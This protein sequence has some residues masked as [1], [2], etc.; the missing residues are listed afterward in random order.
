MIN[1]LKR[2]GLSMNKE[3]GFTL[4]EVL[5]AMV[6]AMVIMAGSYVFF[7]TQ[8]K[9]SVIQTNVSDAQQTLRAAM[10]FMAREFRMIGYDPTVSGNFS[11]TD[12]SDDSGMSAISYSWDAVNGDGIIDGND[13]FRFSLANA[14]PVDGVLDLTRDVGGS[15]SQLMA[16]NIMALGIAY[17]IDTNGDG[18][19][20]QDAGGNT[21]WFIDANNDLDWDQLTVNQAAGTNALADT[22][23]PVKFGDIRSIRIWMLAQSGAPDPNYIDTNI[24]VVGPH[25]SSPASR[26]NNNFR[27]RMQERT[28][29]CRN[30]GMN[31]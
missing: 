6:V 4:I 18:T 31:L 29:L 16:Q 25:I 20:E 27:H 13:T 9:Q 8:Q 11:I 10:D 1:E 19:L 17:A 15:G 28:V 26:P 23:V 22:G 2:M 12:I 21:A 5:I 14:A 24:Y 30:M 3:S 7:N